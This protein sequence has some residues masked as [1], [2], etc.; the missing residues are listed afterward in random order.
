MTEVISYSND[1]A[2]W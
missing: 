1:C 2:C